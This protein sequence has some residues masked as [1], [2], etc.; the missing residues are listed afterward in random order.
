MIFTSLRENFFV[1][2]GFVILTLM[3]FFEPLLKVTTTL[4]EAEVPEK[5]LF[6]V[7]VRDLALGESFKDRRPLM[8]VALLI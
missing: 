4:S 1:V 2:L 3:V 5:L 7:S 6:A 8:L